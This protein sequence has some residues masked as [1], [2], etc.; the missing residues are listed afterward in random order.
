MAVGGVPTIKGMKLA[1]T[2][3]LAFAAPF[4][5]AALIV[6]ARQPGPAVPPGALVL[7]VLLP[8]IVAT[9]LAAGAAL[10]TGEWAPAA[11]A[12]GTMSATAALGVQLL[13]DR[14]VMVLGLTLAAAGYG[15]AAV[16]W[17]PVAAGGRRRGIV[18][19]YAAPLVA[20]AALVGIAT[21]FGT[22]PPGVC[23]G[24]SGAGVGLAL[25]SALHGVAA[26]RL[27]R[28][29]SWAVHAAGASALAVGLAAAGLGVSYAGPLAAMAALLP[30]GAIVIE[31]RQRPGLR[32]YVLGG[33]LGTRLAG[34]GGRDAARAE[35]V[36]MQALRAYSPDLAAHLERTAALS[37]RLG[38]ALGLDQA[39]LAEL[40]TAALF[41]DAGKLFVPVHVLDRHGRPRLRDW[42]H[43]HAHPAMGQQLIA[44]VPALARIA[45]AVGDHHEKF[46]GTGYPAGKRGEGIDLLARIL[47]LADVYDALVSARAYKEGWAPED[48]IAHIRAEAGT[49]FDPAIAEVFLGMLGGVCQA[50]GRCRDAAA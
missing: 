11:I 1:P 38:R 15:L 42:E 39:A 7:A 28:V 23:A 45:G 18:V 17:A 47:T 32:T 30:A 20:L 27:L 34:R 44:R 8:A 35:A 6:V 9:V 16:P 10:R 50:E 36:L 29:S 5:G 14:P 41:H 22:P 13:S 43:L 31:A 26:Y 24:I 40:R 25:L 21:T 33:S 37:V 2:R 4:V 19:L 46:D 12:A 49:H 48:A 3:P